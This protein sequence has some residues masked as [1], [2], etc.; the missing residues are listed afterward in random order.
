MHFDYKR[1]LI[2][3]LYDLFIVDKYNKNLKRRFNCY[4][5]L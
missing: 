4:N 1:Y 2:N 5:I 3:G